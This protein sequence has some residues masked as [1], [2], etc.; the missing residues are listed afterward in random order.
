MD[1]HER[2]GGVNSIMKGGES[3]EAQKQE[4]L[5]GCRQIHRAYAVLMVAGKGRFL[6]TC[7]NLTGESITNMAIAMLDIF[8]TEGLK[9]GTSII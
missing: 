1:L 6:L 5:V 4:A 3:M 7:A 8:R 9:S 2:E